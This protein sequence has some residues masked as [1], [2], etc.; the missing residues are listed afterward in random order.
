MIEPTALT[1]IPRFAG[2]DQTAK[3]WIAARLIRRRWARGDTICRDG[4]PSE[5][6]YL[7]EA[8]SVK[9]VKVLESG[10]ELILGI[11]HAG[12]AFGEVAL[13]DGAGYP[14]N[15]VAHDDAT[16]LILSRSDYYDLMTRYPEAPL[17]TIRDLTLRMRTLRRRM[18]DLGGGGVEYRVARVL[19][20]LAAR[21]GEPDGKGVRI[22]LTLTRQE[23]AGMVGA[24]VETVIR[25]LSRWAR[26]GWLRLTPAGITIDDHDSLEAVANEGGNG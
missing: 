5:A 14:A 22:T 19:L 6:L 11:F 13:I 12:E 9:V 10:R 7:V 20:T 21:C 26:S 25:I 23:L 15:V 16:C 24:R 1:A 4:D 17:A 2:L 18:E 3:A 8:G